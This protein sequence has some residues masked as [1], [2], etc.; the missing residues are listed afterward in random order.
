MEF[1]IEVDGLDDKQRDM[2]FTAAAAMLGPIHH[3]L[4]VAVLEDDGDKFI[5]LVNAAH[6]LADSLMHAMRG[7]CAGEI[8]PKTIEVLQSIQ[9][10][11]EIH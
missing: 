2:V 5:D 6:D 9:P 4:S 11:G 10:H 8:D 3:V 1:G 7:C